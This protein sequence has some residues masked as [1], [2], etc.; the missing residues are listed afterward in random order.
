MSILVIILNRIKSI[1]RTKELYFYV[2]GFPLIFMIIYGSIAGA[3]YPETTPIKIGYVTLDSGTIINLGSMSQRINYGSLF[4][5]YLNNVTFENTSIKAFH[6]MI[7]S[8]AK[9]AEKKVSRLEISAAILI[10]EGFSEAIKRFSESLTRSILLPILSKKANEAFE[11]GNYD[12]GN[13]YIEAI[14]ELENLSESLGTI[15]I[16]I[17][18]D[19]T[20]AGC[21][22]AYEL[23]W[24]HIA[25][26]SFHTAQ[27]FMTNYSD[28]LAKKYNITV[29]VQHP[30]EGSFSGVFNVSFQRIGGK[31]GLKESFLKAYYSVLVPGQIMQTIMLAAVSVIKMLRFEMERGLIGRIKLTR[32]SSSEYIASILAVWGTIALLQGI[33]MIGASLALG[34]IRVLGTVMHYLLSVLIIVLAGVLTAEIS[35]IAVSLIKHESIE[36]ITIGITVSLSLVIAGYFPIENPVIGNFIGYQF[37]LLD[38]IPWRC[39]IIG[40]RKALMLPHIF[41]PLDII[42]ELIL[43][44]LWVIIYGIISSIVFS[45]KILRARE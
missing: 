1:V 24:R 4:Y 5:N 31:E 13:R 10:P 3:Y 45:V 43:L 18:G 9:I 23:I 34:Y 14:Q 36:G 33:I 41:T 6:I 27:V 44:V 7:I 22:R 12:L 29:E 40:L 16:R 26:F 11:S 8:D 2:I 21:M 25:E 17:I 35:M 32:I 28:Y 42:P 39:A 20:N 37:T 19:P 30:E 38:I 15:E